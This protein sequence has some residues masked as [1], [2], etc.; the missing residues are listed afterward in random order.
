MSAARLPNETWRGVAPNIFSKKKKHTHTH[1]KILCGGH[2][3][4]ARLTKCHT[5]ER[6]MVRHVFTL[7]VSQR[8]HLRGSGGRRQPS[9]VAIPF[10][11][12][13]AMTTMEQV[14]TQLQQE[15][16]TLRAQ[17]ASRVLMAE[18]VRAIS[19]LA[20][21]QVRKHTPSLIDVKGLGRPKEFSGREEDFQQRRRRRRS[22]QV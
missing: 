3:L 16:L 4:V 19:T 22:L 6:T 12:E 15:L 20:T 17:I 9:C 10:D 18:A 21:A 1:G 13:G 14:V 5:V 2:S 8:W 7:R 11:A